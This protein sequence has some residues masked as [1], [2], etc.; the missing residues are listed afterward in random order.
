MLQSLLGR[1]G[2]KWGDLPSSFGFVVGEEIPL[3]FALPCGFLLFTCTRKS[4]GAPASLFLLQKKPQG[5]GSGGVSPHVFPPDVPAGRNHLQRAKTL[6]HPDVLKTLETHES[7]A[8][9][10]VVT[11]KC[12]PLPVL[13]YEHQRQQTEPRGRG[14]S[15]QHS[16]CAKSEN[17]EADSKNEKCEEDAKTAKAE[18]EAAAAACVADVVW[19]IYQITSAVAFLH[20]SC[21]MLHGLVNPLSVFVTANGSWRLAAMELARTASAPPATLIADARRSAAALQGWQPPDRVPPGLPPQWIDWWG[22]ASLV[23]WT[24]TTLSSSSTPASFS[25]S[26]ASFSNSSYGSSA[27]GSLFDLSVSSVS[28]HAPLLSPSA[29]QL[30]DR[31]L[32]PSSPSP[33]FLS[34]LLKNDAY[35]SSSTCSCLLFLRE[36]HVK[37]AYEK[38]AFF[39]QELPRMLQAPAQGGAAAH[40]ALPQAVQEQQILPELLKLLDPSIRSFGAPES[41]V[42]SKDACVASSLTPAVVGC[43]AMVAAGMQGPARD[44]SQ[45]RRLR[46]VLEKLFKSSDRAIRYTLLTSFPVLDPLM[47]RS[48]YTR[49]F[50]SLMLGLLDSA[51]PIREATV[52]SLVLVCAK[53][54]DDKK[55]LLQQIFLASLKDGFSPCRQAALQS[56]G[57][58][59]DLFPLQA[60][61]HPLLAGVGGSTLDEEDLAVSEASVETLKQI[62]VAMEK[63]VKEKNAALRAARA[64]KGDQTDTAPP[65]AALNSASAGGY[66]LPS[67]AES[68]WFGAMARTMRAS[69]ASVRRADDCSSRLDFRASP[70][71]SFAS[72]SSSSASPSSSFASSSSSSASPSSSF[73]SSSSSSAS[74]SSSFASSSSVSSYS[75]PS[76]SFSSAASRPPAPRPPPPAEPSRSVRAPVRAFSSHHASASL[77]VLGERERE[78]ER[79]GTV[80]RMVPSREEVAFSKRQATLADDK[81]FHDAADTINAWVED[82]EEISVDSWDVVA[83]SSAALGSSAPKPPSVAS[84]F[85]SPDAPVPPGGSS[86]SLPGGLSAAA[87]ESSRPSASFPSSASMTLTHNHVSP[88]T[89][90]LGSRSLLPS[91][92]SPPGSSLSSSLNR[93]N[94]LT[95]GRGRLRGEGEGKKAA[96]LDGDDFFAEVERELQK[97]RD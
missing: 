5:D 67:A 74:P 95:L 63:K 47:P 13:L 27:C 68:G 71:S 83:P 52:K 32:H 84:C 77:A 62:V 26:R 45:R 85:S 80:S 93:G 17:G 40:A 24:Y 96:A 57:H 55:T 73:A 36:V 91:S 82:D 70:S 69:I 49:I 34:D 61:A 8:A 41:S 56:V 16:V 65:H 66:A 20:E 58:C 76:A 39:E 11:E 12:W 54:G 35:F 28:S 50:D 33:R 19:G 44:D 92:L 78:R 30:L 94:G 29:R 10:Y 89:S 9:L 6:L 86:Y 38:E 60:L 97:E 81:A 4:D 42:S 22:L 37:G 25:S 23:V 72:S 46:N 51:L 7:D 3:P 1:F 43:V 53:I 31:L 75:S 59:L 90:A 21:N 79:P 88:P 48:L 64:G 2:G 87:A 15:S 18:R 14:V